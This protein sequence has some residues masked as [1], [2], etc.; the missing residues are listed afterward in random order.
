MPSNFLNNFFIWER[1]KKT[2][3]HVTQAFPRSGI[4][5]IERTPL[6]PKAS[7]GTGDIRKYEI[8][9]LALASTQSQ[10]RSVAVYHQNSINQTSKYYQNEHAS[11]VFKEKKLH[12]I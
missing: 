1:K 5:Q 8:I 7:Q 11:Y 12:L 3:S 10:T 6:H 4:L 2:C 9:F